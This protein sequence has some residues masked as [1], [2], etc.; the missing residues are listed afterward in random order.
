MKKVEIVGRLDIFS[1]LKGLYYKV[2][3]LIFSIFFFKSRDIH[4]F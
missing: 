1:L 4:N 2:V 3:P